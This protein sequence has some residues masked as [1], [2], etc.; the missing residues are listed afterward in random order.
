M[1]SRRHIAIAI[2]LLLAASCSFAQSN[3]V[4]L[5]V[6][7]S[8]GGPT[9]IAARVIAPLLS[10][11]MGKTVIVD[12]RVGATGAIGADFVARSPADGTTILFGT[13]SIMAANPALMQKLPYDPVRDFAAVST[14]ATIENIMVVHPSVPANNVQEFI[15][16]AKDNPG[17]LFYGSSGTGSTYHLG[18]EMFANMTKTQ[19]GHVPYKGQGPAAQDLLAG[20]IQLMF[21]AFNSA[22]PN[23]KAGRV[24]ALGIASAKRHP[25]LPDLPTISEQGVSGYVTTI[26]LAFFV[27]AKTPTPIVD[28]MNQDLRTIMQRP[29][30]K[31]RFNKLGLQAVSS[32]TQELDSLLKQE[33]AQWSRVVRDAN[34]K[35]E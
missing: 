19:L 24:K 31:E 34:I 8:T 7:F 10:E 20:H 26:W 21:D 27:P 18:S 15:R 30:V 35:P 22:V 2:S 1:I 29:D 33:L 25:D 16:Y 17:K 14:V 12:N 28:K 5:V 23:I 3:T 11:A 4:R 6:P 13:S 9:D 32:S